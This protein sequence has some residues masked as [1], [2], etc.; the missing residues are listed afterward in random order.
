VSESAFISCSLCVHQYLTVTRLCRSKVSTFVGGNVRDVL[1]PSSQVGQYLMTPDGAEVSVD[2]NF[3]GNSPAT[4]KLPS[5]KHTLI[6]TADGY[7]PWTKEIGVFAGSSVK[8]AAK[9]EKNQ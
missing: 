6:V 1:H 2:G 8:L 5:G 9:L 4:L 7:K 3:V